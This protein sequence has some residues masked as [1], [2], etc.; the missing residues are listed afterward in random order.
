[1]ISKNNLFCCSNANDQKKDHEHIFV[2]STISLCNKCESMV[3]TKVL[4]KN[5]KVY[6]KKI[7]PDCGETMNIVSSDAEYYL[8]SYRFNKPGT[9]PLHFN[10]E[11]TKMGCPNDCGIC[12]KHEQHTCLPVIEITDH[13]NLRCPICLVDC[14][15]SYSYSREDF[16]MVLDN[17]IKCEGHLPIITLAGGEP[18]IHP[19]MFD[20][21]KMAIDS[22]KVDRVGINTNGL[23]IADDPQFVEKIIENK[24]NVYVL[25]QFDGWKSN[26][27]TKMRGKNLLDKKLR[28]FD[29][30]EKNNIPATIIA[31]FAQGINDDQIGEIIT[32]G[33]NKSNVLGFTLQPMAYVGAG[34]G[35]FEVDPM[36]LLTLSCVI[37]KLEEQTSGLI[38]RS[39][40]IPIPCSHP[41]CF[42]LSYLL[43]HK[44]GTATP[45]A[46]FIE[47]Q[48][49][50]DIV[51]NKA[52]VSVDDPELEKE[53]NRLSY[54]LWS[55]EAHAPDSEKVMG[56]IKDLLGKLFPSDKYVP[57]PEKIKIGDFSVKTVF[58]H[59]F[60]DKYTYDLERVQKCCN[61]YP[62]VDRLMPICNYNNFYRK[63]GGKL[64]D[65][66][67]VK[68]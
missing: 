12:E 6:F 57:R 51:K 32:F 59:G 15:G 10:K 43:K 14:K 7:C 38:K 66:I 52:L 42:S 37:N 23:V 18:T 68:I 55:G 28:A 47:L 39:D 26:S 29:I 44:D 8:G 9:I 4:L 30:L 22:G 2:K 24:N 13:C 20:F 61:Q 62:Q 25:M 33:L 3:F 40:F 27:Y 11:S 54:S 19:L 31:T 60:M 17:L 63:N 35:H 46:R 56:T 58:V 5:N 36:N 64:L 50:M 1:M 53:F 34:G 21:V 45:F 16:K 49:I 41:N 48:K 67:Q 65:K